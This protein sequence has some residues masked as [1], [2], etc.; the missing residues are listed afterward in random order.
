METNASRGA[1]A[2]GSGSET[3]LRGMETRRK[4]GIANPFRTQ[5]PSLEGWKPGAAD[6]PDARPGGSETFLRGMETDLL[7]DG[8]LPRPGSETF[9]RGME[10]R[11][12]ANRHGGGDELRNLP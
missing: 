11:Y 12:R 10:T 7:P 5:K 1:G 6:R 2:G 9:L 8:H 4:R 3:F